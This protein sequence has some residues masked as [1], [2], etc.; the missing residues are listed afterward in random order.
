MFFDKNKKKDKCSGCNKI[1][2]NSYSFCPNCGT[3][4][5]YPG[6]QMDDYGL[7]GKSDTNESEENLLMQN[8]QGIT[9]SIFDKLIGSMIKSIDK[10]F[11]NKFKNMDFSEGSPKNSEILAL[12]NGV[13]IKISG[14]YPVKQSPKPKKTKNFEIDENLIKRINSLPKEKAKTEMKRIGNKVYYE[15]KTPGVTSPHDVIVSKLESGYEI[16]AVGNKKV[17]VNSIPINL[18]LKSYSI[19][20]NK[21]LFEFLTQNVQ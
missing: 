18:P 3:P 10:Q 20:D 6:K 8:N 11:Q 2:N 17:Y 21:L 14:P 1:V 15:L 19:V 7:L 5:V 16:K 13:K 9:E 12:P 4:F